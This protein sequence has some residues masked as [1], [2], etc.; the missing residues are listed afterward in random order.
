MPTVDETREIADNARVGFLFGDHAEVDQVSACIQRVPRSASGNATTVSVYA[1]EAA[2]MRS[3]LSH[4]G[5][6]NPE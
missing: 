6:H 5:G 2:I 4:C 1:C 3:R